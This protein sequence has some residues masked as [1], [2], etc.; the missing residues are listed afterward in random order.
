[1][2]SVKVPATSANL[3]PGFD[4]MGFALQVYNSIDVQEIS[5]GLEINISDDT[6]KFLPK[7]EKNLVYQSMVKIFEKVGYYP[8]GLR[9]NMENKIPV[10]RGLGSSSACVVGGLFAANALSG[11]QLRKEELI[12][13]AAQIEGHPDNSTPAILGGMVVA[14]QDKEDVHYV[15]TA[16]SEILQFAVFIPNFTLAT[17]KARKI[18]PDTIPHSD[19]VFNTGR[20]ALMAASLITGNLKNITM[21]VEDKL[22]QPYREKFIPGMKEI[23]EISRKNGAKGVFLSGAGPTLIAILD[24]NYQ[25]FKIEVSKQLKQK[26]PDWT[27]EMISPDN[28]GVKISVNNE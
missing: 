17:K 6:A 12:R 20:A 2:I 19:G 18:L 5:S 9:I 8:K 7:D 25:D 11:N 24:K 27:V 22:H 16:L 15:R 26:V 13:I 28:E 4:C 14:V 1:M 23:F 10:T 3:G 21:A